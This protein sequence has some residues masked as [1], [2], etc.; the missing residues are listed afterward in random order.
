MGWEHRQR[1]GKYYTRSRRIN[2]RVVREYLGSGEVAEACAE[3]DALDRRERKR[4]EAAFRA[5]CERL[6]AIDRTTR[7]FSALVDSLA[8]GALLAAGYRQ[9]H[10]GEWRRRRHDGKE[11]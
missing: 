6:E 9:H 5:D 8:Q 10:R 2:G 3:L 1:G 7:E 4:K 11:A